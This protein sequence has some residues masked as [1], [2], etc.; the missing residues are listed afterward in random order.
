MEA[1]RRM[2]QNSKLLSI[3]TVIPGAH[4]MGG[5]KWLMM[6]RPRPLQLLKVVSPV[7]ALL[8]GLRFR[9]GIASILTNSTIL[10]IASAVALITA[11]DIQRER[12]LFR[13]KLEER[14]LSSQHA[15]YHLI[16]S[17]SFQ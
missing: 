6:M 13:D 8:P 15:E 5:V 7:M 1:G 9:W 14:A 10:L 12:A 11:L 4:A 17:P 2:A 3:D 16:S